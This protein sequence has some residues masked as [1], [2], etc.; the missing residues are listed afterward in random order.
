[1]VKF[2]LAQVVIFRLSFRGGQCYI[3]LA[4]LCDFALLLQPMLDAS[5]TLWPLVCRLRREGRGKMIGINRL[6][7]SVK[8]KDLTLS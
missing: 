1:M 5:A 6:V 4:G 2:G 8:D 3:M 7:E